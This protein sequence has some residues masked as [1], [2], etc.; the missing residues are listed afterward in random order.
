MNRRLDRYH[1]Q[2][3]KNLKAGK[4]FN[5][6]T[7]NQPVMLQFKRSRVMYNIALL[8]ELKQASLVG[9]DNTL[10]VQGEMVLLLNT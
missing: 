3:L 9:T 2:I 7:Q 8:D 6:L 1:M 4:P 10:T 5:L